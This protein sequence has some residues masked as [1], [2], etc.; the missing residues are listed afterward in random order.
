MTAPP[1]NERELRARARAIAGRTLGELAR[2]FDFPLPPDTRRRK[3][4]VG[5][6]LEQAL[7][8]DA[9]RADAPDFS[10]LG[11]EL[12]TLPI[13][14][15]G[16]PRESTF[17][18]HIDLLKAAETDWERSRVHRKLRRVLWVPVEAA[19][20]VPLAGRRVG[21]AF[22]WS[23]DADERDT[24]QRDWEEL[25]GLIGSGHVE[26]IT[27][28]L[29]EALQVRPKG[30][31]ARARTRAEGFEGAWLQTMPRGFYL[32]ARFTMHIVRRALRA[33]AET[34]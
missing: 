14:G 15:S 16:R 33:E 13:D 7:G 25:S 26:A 2:S 23:P 24:L 5:Q 27:A 20:T 17:V 21:S 28:H 11:I 1:A 29:G 8:A 30:P 31:H 9:T 22:L 10:A 4:C 18:C 3:G 6:L 32:R 19:P 34:T 12:K